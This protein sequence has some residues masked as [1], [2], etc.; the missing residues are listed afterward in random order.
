VESTDVIAEV[1]VKALGED[2]QI[3]L[4]IAASLQE[5]LPLQADG[6]I[7]SSGDGSQT[8]KP[9]EHQSEI[10]EKEPVEAPKPQ[11]QHLPAKKTKEPKSSP[12]A[13]CRSFLRCRSKGQ[14]QS[15]SI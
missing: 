4:A 14:K 8:T 7:P 2:E 13:S 15:L 11:Q 3:A 1:D 6:R 10:V 12:R 5:P 9:A